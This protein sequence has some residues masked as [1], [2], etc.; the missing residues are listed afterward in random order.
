MLGERIKA[1]RIEK[2]LMQQDLAEA[3]NVAQSTVGMWETNKREPDIDTIKKIAIFLECPIAFLLNDTMKIGK[4]YTSDNLPVHCC[5][6]CGH[7]YVHLEDS[8]LADFYQSP[9]SSGY[10]LKFS[11]EAGHSFYII[12]EN[13]KGHNYMT[14]TDDKFSPLKSIAIDSVSSEIEYKISKLDKYGRKAILGL[15][16]TE[17][18]RCTS[19]SKQKIIVFKR[20]SVHKVSA[21]CGYDL[22]DADN[23]EDLEVVDTPE[24]QKADF[25]VEIDGRSMEPTYQNGDIVYVV[26][27]TDV[28]VGKI[29]LFIQNNKG[30]IKE[31]GNDRLISHNDEYPDIYPEDGE[32]ICVGR[33]IGTAELPQQ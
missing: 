7:D 11:C 5:P 21:G 24:A 19:T 28:P 14:Y 32:I 2:K 22:E 27:D 4:E 12:I 17:Y 13:H 23:W 9:K 31:K 29:G 30:Y 16:N 1:L 6:I 18:E 25:A 15:L 26:S 33:V 20:F 3:L 8:I 10:A